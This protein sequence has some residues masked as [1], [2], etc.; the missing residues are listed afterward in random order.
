MQFPLDT[1][2]KLI[3]GLRR[4]SGSGHYGNGGHG[5][6]GEEDTNKAV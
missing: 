6:H 3:G 5:G 2:L 1:L 4:G